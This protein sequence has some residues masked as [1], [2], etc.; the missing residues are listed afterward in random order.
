MEHYKKSSC[1]RRKTNEDKKSNRDDLV[2]K[3]GDEKIKKYEEYLKKLKEHEY[4]VEQDGM[5][6]LNVKKRITKT[7]IMKQ[8]Y[9]CIWHAKICEKCEL[10]YKN[11]GTPWEILSHYIFDKNG[12]RFK[13]KS[14]RKSK[15]TV[16]PNDILDAFKK[17]GFPL[18]DDKKRET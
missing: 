1:K 7:L 5:Y 2:K 8:T 9:L 17:D 13:K 15:P 11:G 18:E 14:I 12:N 10:Y 6:K 3:Y 4:I 16:P